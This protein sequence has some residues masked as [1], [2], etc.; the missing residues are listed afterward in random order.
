MPVEIYQPSYGELQ[1]TDHKHV[2]ANNS[3]LDVKGCVTLK[4]SNNQTTITELPAIHSLG[5]IYQIPRT[6]SIRS[7][8]THH[9]STL[10]LLREDIVREYTQLFLENRK[11]P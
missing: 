1:P 7:I 2:G 5:L 4:L 6:F 10:R 9:D 3:Q 8:D 11:L